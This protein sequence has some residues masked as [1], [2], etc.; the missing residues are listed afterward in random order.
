MSIEEAKQ[1][2]F[3]TDMTVEFEAIEQYIISS[4]L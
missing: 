2:K 1:K 3:T 4:N